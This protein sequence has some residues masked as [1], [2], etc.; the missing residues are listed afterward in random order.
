[1]SNM[2]LKNSEYIYR[3]II[4]KYVIIVI[5]QNTRVLGD[6]SIFFFV[7]GGRLEYSLIQLVLDKIVNLF[8]CYT[9]TWH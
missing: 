5:N 8:V 2:L 1:M 7:G 3:E 6:Y 4:I 9:S